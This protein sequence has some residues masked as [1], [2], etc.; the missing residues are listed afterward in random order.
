[1]SIAG[2]AAMLALGGCSGS[3]SDGSSTGNR[4]ADGA[5]PAQPGGAAQNGAAGKQ[6]AE[7]QPGAGAGQVDLR[8]PQ[9]AIIYT[10]SLTV[11]VPDVDAAATRAGTIVT[12][13]GGYV[14]GDQ[15]SR[16]GSE[17]ATLVLR[18]PAERFQRVVADLA[19]LGEAEKRELNSQD[20]TEETVDLDARIATQRARVD[21]GRRLLAQAKSLADL[22]SLES[23]VAKREADL[24]SLEA[25]QRRLADL[26]ALSTVTLDLVEAEAAPV[27]AKDD[28]GGFLAGLG[29][30]WEALR[31]VVG[32][33]LIVLGALL[34]F[35]LVF[36]VPALLAAWL[37]RRRRRRT[38]TPAVPA[39]RTPE[40]PD[41]K[42]PEPAA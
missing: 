1:M 3:D 9:R 5:A 23:E 41:Q 21:S 28:R 15:R 38:A 17:Q 25:K 14:G 11:R 12:G 26:T 20:V 42:V 18:V 37:V 40:A 27:A 10:G 16:D 4:A 39:A 32:V 8:A 30:G 2:L 7:A 29:G 33:L 6:G 22:V 13:V 31:E 24:A 19:G 34:P 35:A 36:G